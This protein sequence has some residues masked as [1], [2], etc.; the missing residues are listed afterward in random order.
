MR[1]TPP[2]VPKCR[3]DHGPLM[4]VTSAGDT[5]E[6]ALLS[7]KQHNKMSE[8]TGFRLALFVCE[9]CGY[10]ELFDLDPEETAKN[11]AGR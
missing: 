1:N 2:I 9:N 6:W 8:V 5:P 7:G 4:R 3:Y 11:E 10:S